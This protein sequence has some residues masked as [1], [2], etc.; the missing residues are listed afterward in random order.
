MHSMAWHELFRLRPVADIL[1]EYSKV[2]LIDSLNPSKI[3]L[4]IDKGIL[5]AMPIFY[6]LGLQFA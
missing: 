5:G 2:T 3:W 1:A 6:M 4:R